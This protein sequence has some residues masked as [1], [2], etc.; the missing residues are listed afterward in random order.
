MRGFFSMAAIS[1]ATHVVFF[2]ESRKLTTDA[3]RL[4][5]RGDGQCLELRNGGNKHA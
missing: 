5:V 2:G 1:L 3:A 4:S